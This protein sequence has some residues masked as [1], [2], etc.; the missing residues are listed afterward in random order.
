MVLAPPFV[1]PSEMWRSS[2]Q[3]VSQ[4]L[5]AQGRPKANA[6]KLVE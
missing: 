3:T 1:S 4:D 6:P 2:P 5:T